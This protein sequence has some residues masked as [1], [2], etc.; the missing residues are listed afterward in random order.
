MGAFAVGICEMKNQLLTLFVFLM[1]LNGSAQAFEP[2]EDSAGTVI[3]HS[4]ETT[5][6]YLFQGKP[7]KSHNKE[8][9]RHRYAGSIK[10]FSRVADCL[11]KDESQ[12]PQPD[13]T[14]ID[15]NKINTNEDAAVCLLR[16]ASSYS[17]PQDME[18]WMELQG[19]E[20]VSGIVQAGKYF[21]LNGSW[22]IKKNGVKFSSNWFVKFYLENIAYNT[23]FSVG[24]YEDSVVYA[25]GITQN[26][27]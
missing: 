13:L 24:Y 27:L 23:S 10:D 25:T 12:K 19:F 21:F 22:D 18:Q 3:R 6:P 15:W 20:V 14:K 8:H 1:L 9:I 7:A 5:E 2:Y 26:S 17:K 11:I 4:S 16:I